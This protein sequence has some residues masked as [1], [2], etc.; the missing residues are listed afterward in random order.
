M[1]HKVIYY[2]EPGGARTRRAIDLAPG[3]LDCGTVDPA[4]DEDERVRQLAEC[5]AL[6][7]NGL[8]LTTDFLKRMPRLKLLQLMSAGFDRL[9]VPAVRE[10]GIEVCN[11]S[12][13]I[14][15]SVAEH[16]VALMLMVYK[17][18]VQGVD[19][20][21]NGTWQ[22]PAKSGPYGTLYELTGR[23]VGI[24]GL[25]HIGSNVARRLRGFDTT[26]LYHDIREFPRDKEQELQVTRTSFDELLERSDVV[27]VHVPLYSATTKMFSR[28]EF[29]AMRNDAIFIN[30][31]RGPVQD[32]SALIEAL[33]TGEIAAAGL[34]VTEVEPT[35]LD[36]PL[37]KMDNV[38]VTP[39]LAGSSQERV[40]RALVFSYENARRV[41]SGEK[42]LSPVQI[43]D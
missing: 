22:G 35:P 14:A 23:T 3:D 32:E 31:C 33:Q 26:T 39:H 1:G 15:N 30:T 5:E 9:D 8:D 13:A 21:K 41:L 4:L 37:L 40:D 27:T 11:N 6:I 2:G 7:T 25:G 43:L 19:G 29:K 34:D 10:H 16:A 36:S 17:R 28:N 12:P 20:V 38:V 42:P 18:L 24:V